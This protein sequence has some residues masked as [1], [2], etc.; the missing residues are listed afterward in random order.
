[1]YTWQEGDIIRRDN[2]HS[3]DLFT[4]GTDGYALFTFDPGHSGR[5][6]N[7]QFSAGENPYLH[8]DIVKWKYCAHALRTAANYNSAGLLLDSTSFVAGYDAAD[9]MVTCVTSRYVPG[10]SPGSDTTTYTYRCK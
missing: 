8:E 10:F 2:Y 5:Q 7:T 4:Y 1:V 3:G 6:M 9:R